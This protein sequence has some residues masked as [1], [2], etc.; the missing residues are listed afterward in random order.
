MHFI[1]KIYTLIIISGYICVYSNQIRRSLSFL[2]HFFFN[3]K[4]WTRISETKSQLAQSGLP[5]MSKITV[6][7]RGFVS[8]MAVFTLWRFYR[9]WLSFVV[10]LSGQL[11]LYSENADCSFPAMCQSYRDYKEFAF[12]TALKYLLNFASLL[13]V[14]FSTALKEMT[15]LYSSSLV[16]RLEF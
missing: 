16:C 1:Y 5:P 12:S 4:F 9:E 2:S 13:S 8:W 11:C 10:A 6:Q 3:R 7:I 14:G 15:Y